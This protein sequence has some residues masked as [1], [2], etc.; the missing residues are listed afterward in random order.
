MEM[1]LMSAPLVVV[2]I[3]GRTVQSTRHKCGLASKANSKV[4]DPAEDPGTSLGFKDTTVVRLERNSSTPI[5][6]RK[7]LAAELSPIG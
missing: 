1:S 3:L 6:F 2:E 5:T 7:A 4:E